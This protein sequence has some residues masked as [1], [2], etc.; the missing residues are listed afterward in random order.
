MNT[1]KLTLSIPKKILSEAK[2]YSKKTHQPL[3]RLVSRYFAFLSA[4]TSKD[5]DIT[6]AIKRVTGLVHSDKNE[7]ELLSGAMLG[8]YVILD[9]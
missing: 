3:S 8:K 9:K 5:A 6:P 4:K 2:V 7:K 1:A